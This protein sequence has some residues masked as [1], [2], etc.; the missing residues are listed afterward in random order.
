MLAQG[1][2]IGETEKRREQNSLEK[3]INT[4]EE[5]ERKKHEQP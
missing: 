4:K 1:T 3:K 2:V 5:Q